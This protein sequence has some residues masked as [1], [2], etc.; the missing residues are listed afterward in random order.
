MPIIKNFVHEAATA[1][2]PQPRIQNNILK[3]KDAT[4]KVVKRRKPQFRNAEDEFEAVDALFMVASIIF[5]EAESHLS[6]LEEAI[7]TS[8]GNELRS[9]EQEKIK[10]KAA[11]SAASFAKHDCI[12][13]EAAVERKHYQ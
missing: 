10:A 2:P 4:K 6:T 1:P 11:V 7:I 13:K 5:E 3:K 9:L 12:W 8:T